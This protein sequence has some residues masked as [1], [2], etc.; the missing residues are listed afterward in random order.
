MSE[1]RRINVGHGML[2]KEKAVL[3]LLG[4][5]ADVPMNLVKH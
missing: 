1:I 3:F 4:I 2:W 5:M